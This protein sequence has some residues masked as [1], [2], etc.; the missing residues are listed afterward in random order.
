MEKVIEHTLHIHTSRLPT[1]KKLKDLATVLMSHSVLSETFDL[2]N[3][4]EP[5]AD[6]H[7]DL[8][9][10]LGVRSGTVEQHMLADTVKL[11]IY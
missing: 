9:A 2:S 1:E 8:L 3:E 7:S 6:I 11:I 4:S 10:R 5:K